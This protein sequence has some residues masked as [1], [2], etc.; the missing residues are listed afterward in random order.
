MP[1]PVKRQH[2]SPRPVDAAWKDSL[3][4]FFPAFLEQFFPEL[5]AQR[6]AARPVRFLDTELRRIQR[7]AR[8]GTRHVDVL[9]EI[10]LLEEGDVWLLVHVEVQS[11]KDPDFPHRM[12]VYHYRTYDLYRRPVVSLAIL[13]DSDPDWKENC[14]QTAHAGCR[15][16]FTFPLVKLLDWRERV[17]ELESSRNPFALVVASHLRSLEAGPTSPQRLQARLRLYRM[18]LGLGLS[19]DEVDGLM[20]ILDVTMELSPELEEMFDKQVQEEEEEA[21]ELTV[22]NRWL[23]KGLEQGREEGLEQGREEGVERGRKEERR[24]MVQRMLANGLS[25]KQVLEIA[26]LS[27]EEELEL[28]LAGANEGG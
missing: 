20:L 8:V 9:A 18:L 2:R 1:K 5:A 26:R 28:L 19:R 13:A 12:W 7:R 23:E 25:R 11:R 3:R 27:S 15:L 24:A 16:V 17:E 21:M 14:Y 22:P 4:L 10:P 6:D